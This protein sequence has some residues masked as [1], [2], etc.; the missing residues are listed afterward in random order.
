MDPLSITVA[1]VSLVA[2]IRTLLVSVNDFARKVRDAQSDI[3][4]VKNELESVQYTLK[5][6]TDNDLIVPQ[7]LTVQFSGII[8]Q[9]RG[10]VDQIKTS[11]D[12]Q[13]AARISRRIR[14]VVSGRED[15]EKLRSS[16]E[17]HK[18]A[19]N[20]AVDCLALYISTPCLLNLR[21]SL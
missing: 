14:W 4:L 12:E 15:M 6:L 19:L 9:T 21:T 8:T 20:L 11:I 3:D 7:A 16:L 2:G 18:S 17:Q 1:A 5:F 13:S 10:I